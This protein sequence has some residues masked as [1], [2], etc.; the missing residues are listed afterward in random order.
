[1][2][3]LYTGERWNY[4]I[5]GLENNEWKKHLCGCIYDIVCISVLNSS[6]WCIFLSLHKYMYEY[7]YMYAYVYS[8]VQTSIYIFNVKIML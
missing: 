5:Q 2:H 7:M 4:V 1:M 3:Y 6:K 8:Y